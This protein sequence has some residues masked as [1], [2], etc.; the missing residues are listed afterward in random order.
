M[1][2]EA[3]SAL[4]FDE[5]YVVPAEQSA[6]K[7]FATFEHG[8]GHSHDMADVMATACLVAVIESI[9]IGELAVD[10]C[11]R[12]R[13]KAHDSCGAAKRCRLAHQFASQGAVAGQAQLHLGPA[14]GEVAG[15]F[16]QHG[17]ALV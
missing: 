11:R 2:H 12:Q 10:V 3:V 17:D 8:S 5:A 7:L 16:E 14:C 15:D 4:F 13:A 6:R 1:N 9:C